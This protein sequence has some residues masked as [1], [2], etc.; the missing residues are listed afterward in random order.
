MTLVSD[1]QKQ[2]PGSELVQLFEI[3]KPDGSFAYFTSEEESKPPD[4]EKATGTS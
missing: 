4:N 3:E 1:F 2:S